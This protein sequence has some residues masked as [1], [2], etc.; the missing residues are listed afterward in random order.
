MPLNV[1]HALTNIS[2]TGFVSFTDPPQLA[3]LSNGGYALA[4]FGRTRVKASPIF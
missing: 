4:Y 2:N 1:I 3:T